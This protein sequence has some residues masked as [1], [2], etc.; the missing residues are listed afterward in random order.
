MYRM[1]AKVVSI[2]EYKLK[3]KYPGMMEEG[4]NIFM[5]DSNIES[6]LTVLTLNI[7]SM[8]CDNCVILLAVYGYFA[9]EAYIFTVEV[10]ERER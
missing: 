6:E 5:V 10:I 4:E 7:K 9:D 8:E 2:S 3:E 1:V